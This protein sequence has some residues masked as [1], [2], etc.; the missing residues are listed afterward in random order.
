MTGVED[1]LGRLVAERLTARADV[2]AV[3]GVVRAATP[4]VAG[5]EV[6]RLSREYEGVSDLVRERGIDTIIHADRP[7]VRSRRGGS[8]SVLNVINTMQL[9]AAASHRAASVRAVVMVSSTRVYP[10][11][12][13]AARLHPESE[14][15]SPRRGSLAASLVE[16][17]G[18][19]R[20]LAT[21]NPN[22]S[23]SIVR[24]AD[25]A[26]LADLTDLSDLAVRRTHDPLSELLAS[27]VV[28][29]VW[30]FD[31]S[32]QLLHIDDAVAALEHAADHDLAGVYN[33]GADELVR[34]RQAIRLA[35]KPHVELPATATRTLTGI[36][37]RAYRV[38]A[39]DDLVNELKFGRVAATEAIAR[40]GF[41]PTR[42]SVH[43]IPV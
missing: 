39:G 23:A 14:P 33:V 12:S 37:Q 9:A 31:P 29:T 35:R 32:V 34:W 22:L 43:C 13:R 11:S 5:V 20:D 3:L 27:P 16:A 17:E 1:R 4:V 30:G 26:D 2:E 7:W 28:P 25:L 10:V 8:G 18:Y 41:R 6:V 40:T 24:L 15:L 21:T 42:T 38:T 36:L 19:V